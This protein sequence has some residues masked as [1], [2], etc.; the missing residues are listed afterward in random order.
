M[1]PTTKDTKTRKS[2]KFH[3]RISFGSGAV[4]RFRFIEGARTLMAIIVIFHH[5]DLINPRINR[6]S[7]LIWDVSRH[8]ELV[9][10]Q[11][12]IKQKAINELKQQ[13]LHN[14]NHDLPDV[15][16]DPMHP[17]RHNNN[18]PDIVVNNNGNGRGLLSE[19]GRPH[20]GKLTAFGMFASV[21]D[22]TLFCLITGYV[23][24][25]VAFKYYNYDFE[26]ENNMD[27]NIVLCTT[28][29]PF[30]IYK[31]VR[32]IIR[33][34][35]KMMFSLF[36]VQ[37][38][39][40]LLWY[41]D[42]VHLRGSEQWKT[43]DYY[44]A[45]W[46]D[47]CHFGA[48]FW[49]EINGALWVCDIFF[50]STFSCFIVLSITI[51]ITEIKYRIYIY[52]LFCILF[53]NG[54]YLPILMGIIGAD[55]DYHGYYQKYFTSKKYIHNLIAA[56]VLLLFIE[57]PYIEF[58]AGSYLIGKC[59]GW[60]NLGLYCCQYPDS[61]VTRFFAHDYLC[62]WGQYT[63]SLYIWHM[64]VYRF[65]GTNITPLLLDVKDKTIKSLLYMDWI[66][67]FC[68]AF[69]SFIFAILFNKLM[70]NPWNN[71]VVKPLLNKFQSLQNEN[72]KKA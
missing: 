46:S 3:S 48:F 59:I 32:L 61:I 23:I 52:I 8:Q 57:I 64:I 37:F 5:V 63:F 36:W 38:A 42:L 20:G 28:N 41:F 33:R 25:L 43:R 21:F 30:W 72:D 60:F 22:I 13:K 6:V 34:S 71:H 11:E 19:K 27:K 2:R 4:N 58:H 53:R 29:Y 66:I 1:L 49:S 24:S 12:I 62:Y 65:M 54:Y 51:N 47:N 16:A 40:F 15:L 69:T 67:I 9:Q 68:G 39:T 55:I 14:N 10:K 50:W 18:I 7:N 56:S 70:E 45:F 35:L 26:F 44:E 31:F 17:F